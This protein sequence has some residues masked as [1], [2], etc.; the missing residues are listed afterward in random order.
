MLNLLCFLKILE[1]RMNDELLVS[2]SSSSSLLGCVCVCELFCSV[3]VCVFTLTTPWSKGWG[4][5]RLAI[6]DRFALY[7]QGNLFN[8]QTWGL[9]FFFFFWTVIY[10]SLP[11][12]QLWA[13]QLWIYISSI[14]KLGVF[15]FQLW[16]YISPIL[17]LCFSICG[18]MSSNCCF[19]ISIKL[20]SVFLALKAIF[21]KRFCTTGQHGSFSFWVTEKHSKSVEFLLNTNFILQQKRSKKEGEKIDRSQ[22]IRHIQAFYRSYRE[23][24]RVDQV[25]EEVRRGLERQSSDQDTSTYVACSYNY[26]LSSSLLVLYA[27]IIWVVKNQRFWCMR[28][29]NHIFSML[30]S[31]TDSVSSW[32]IQLLMKMNWKCIYHGEDGDM[33]YHWFL[34]KF[35]RLLVPGCCNFS[36]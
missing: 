17:N 28:N 19:Q 26:S 35:L 3:W 13:F 7:H 21:Q 15:F 20:H 11:N 14:L 31:F 9:F 29:C 8:S 22:D 16:I 4:S 1:E 18:C 23:R 34:R 12:S 32:E 5:W 27:E 36:F 33:G 2:S 24:N 25:E 6:Q 30:F 10:I